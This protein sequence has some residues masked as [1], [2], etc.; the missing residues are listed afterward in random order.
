[1]GAFSKILFVSL[2]NQFRLKPKGRRASREIIAFLREQGFA[3]R[4]VE[5]WM[6]LAEPSGLCCLVFFREDA[7]LARFELA[8]HLP[9]ITA[10]FREALAQTAYP[11]EAVSLVD[12]SVHS[13]EAIKRSGGYYPYF[14]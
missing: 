13:D 1:M 12:V 14:K 10:R 5:V 7:E 4:S 2:R 3:F 11:A 6:G 9:T 8:R